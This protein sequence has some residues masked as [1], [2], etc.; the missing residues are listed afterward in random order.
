MMETEFFDIFSED[1]TK[2]GK[3]SRSNVHAKGLWH[4]TFHCWIIKK[5]SGEGLHILFQLR[6]KNKD[7]FPS[8]LDISCAG[9]LQSGESVE[10]G[11]RELHEE[12][13]ISVTFKDLISCG[14]VAQ[15]HVFS[16]AL[17]DREFNNVFIYE[18]DKPLEE[19][20]IQETELSGLYWVDYKEFK[21]LLNRDRD[22]LTSEGFFV[23]EVSRSFMN[24]TR[25][26]FREDFTP[27]SDKYYKILFE[28]INKYLK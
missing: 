27:N 12:L 19:Y 14:M 9:H 18:S 13:G 6:H 23:D 20:S 2:I 22:Y 26:L 16:D 10:D 1:M 24:D 15:E 17:I 4:Q 11:V 28:K 5:S 7:I 25:K 3:E 8:L 21:E